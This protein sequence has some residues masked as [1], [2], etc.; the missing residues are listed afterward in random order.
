LDNLKSFDEFLGAAVPEIKK[1]GEP[2]DAYTRT[3]AASGE[4]GP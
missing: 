1:E 2:L 3:P 4:E